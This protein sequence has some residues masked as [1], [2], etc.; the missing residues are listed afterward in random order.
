MMH[1]ENNRT[2]GILSAGFLTLGI[3]AVFVAL[4]LIIKLSLFGI[5]QFLTDNIVVLNQILALIILSLIFLLLIGSERIP[6]LSRAPQ[7]SQNVLSTA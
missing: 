5:G 7:L 1:T 4:G 6:L 2:K 3:L